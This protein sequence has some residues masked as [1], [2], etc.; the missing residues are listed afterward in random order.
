VLGVRAGREIGVPARSA[1]TSPNLKTSSTSRQ[2]FLTAIDIIRP[3]LYTGAVISPEQS[4]AAR[5]L[6]GWT[7]SELAAAADV[8]MSTIRDF[9]RGARTPGI[10][11]LKAIRWALEQAGV[12]I[13][14]G[15]APGARRRAPASAGP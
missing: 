2:T 5:A 1:W 3:R 13:L 8:S 12:E 10:N 7:Q 4:R 9:E 15:D 14:D 6:I 11:N